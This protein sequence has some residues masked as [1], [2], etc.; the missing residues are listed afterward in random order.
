MKKYSNNGIYNQI[1]QTKMAYSQSTLHELF[2]EQ[3]EMFPNLIALE[4]EDKQLT[5]N[6]LNKTIDRTVDLFLEQVDKT[7]D[8]I[9][10][11]IQIVETYLK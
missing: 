1:N 2:A 10:S 6:K 4:F 3:A 11:C 8:E 5:H 7:P 9:P